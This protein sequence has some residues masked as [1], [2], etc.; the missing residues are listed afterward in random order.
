MSSTLWVPN[1]P[2]FVRAI[3]IALSPGNCY[4]QLLSIGAIQAPKDVQLLMHCVN[5]LEKLAERDSTALLLTVALQNTDTQAFLA[6][7]LAQ[8]FTEPGFVY[9]LSW[10]IYSHLRYE[11]PWQSVMSGDSY[12]LEEACVPLVREMIQATETLY[13][14]A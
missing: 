6:Y 12:W 4:N 3:A 11:R 9:T 14:C 13:K 7:E 1:Q 10:I 5:E 2:Q 8:N